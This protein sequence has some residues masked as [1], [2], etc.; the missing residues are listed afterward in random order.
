[1]CMCVCMNIYMHI[2]FWKLQLAASGKKVHMDMYIYMYVYKR[3]IA[4]LYR[5]MHTYI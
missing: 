1:M 4:A 3:Q 5:K 2:C